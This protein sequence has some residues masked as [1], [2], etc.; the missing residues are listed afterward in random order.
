MFDSLEEYHAVRDDDPISTSTADD[1]LVIRGRRAERATRACRRSATCRCPPSCSEKGVDDMVRICDA[2]MSGTGYGTVVL[3]VS[4]EA[5][6]GGPLALVRTGDRIGLDVPARSLTVDVSDDELAQRAEAWSPTPARRTVGLPLAVPRARPAGR[7]RRGPRLPH[8]ITGRRSAPRLALT[9]VGRTPAFSA[10]APGSA[11]AGWGLPADWNPG[12]DI[13]KL[14]TGTVELALGLDPAADV[15]LT[16]R[17][18]LEWTPAPG[19][20]ATMPARVGIARH[21]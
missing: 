5:A 15:T 18:C 20:A 6:V 10:Y 12:N 9:S 4:P 2:R 1:V 16:A 11:H 17:Q 8:R 21:G 14:L 19:S 3:H 7:R 13:N